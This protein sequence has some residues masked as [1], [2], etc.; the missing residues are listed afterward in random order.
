MGIKS[1]C[2]RV[3]KGKRDPG[4]IGSAAHLFAERK[5]LERTNLRLNPADNSV[6]L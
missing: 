5:F 4:I 3:G 6:R 1:G 2:W